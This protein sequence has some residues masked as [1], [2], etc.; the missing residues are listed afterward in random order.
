LPKYGLKVGLKNYSAAYCTGLLCA[1]KFAN[2]VKP[3]LSK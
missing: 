3:C 2:K 1:I